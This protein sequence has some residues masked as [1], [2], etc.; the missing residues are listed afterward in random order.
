MSSET[1]D[2]VHHF[3]RWLKRTTKQYGLIDKLDFRKSITPFVWF[4]FELQAK[5]GM[6]DFE[7][8]DMGHMGHMG[9]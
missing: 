8:D 6:P 4:Q 3:S 2:E 5:F 7:T 1:I 9:H